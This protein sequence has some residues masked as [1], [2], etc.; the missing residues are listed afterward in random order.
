MITALLPA[1]NEADVLPATIASL[2]AQ[3][4][5]PDRIIVVSDN[6][7]DA[8]VR[9]AEQLNVDVIETVGN[10]HRKAGALNQALA[11]LD[12]DGLVL[13]MDSD[14]ELVPTWIETALTELDDPTVGA[15]GAVFRGDTPK[16]YLQLCQYL[17]WSRYAEQ[18]ERTGKTFVLSGTAALI[19]WEALEDVRARFGHWYDTDTI[20]EDSRLT[21]DLKMTGW[22]LRSRVEL[23]ATT[24]TMPS[25][26]MLWLQRRRWNLGAMQNVADLGFN[27]VTA[28]YWGQQVML[29]LCVLLL[30]G[31]IS[32]T[33]LALI[34]VG[35]TAPQLFWLSIGVVFIIERVLTVWDEPVRYRLFAALVVPELIY[36][37]ILQTAYVAAVVQKITGS[38]GSWHHV[39]PNDATTTRELE[40][41]R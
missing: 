27:R 36:A 28:P 25:V 1:H 30:W 12:R 5:S 19:R 22:K 37:L 38:A 34:I 10:T 21:L 23:Q 4:I 3:T 35:P 8:T 6:S 15:V 24:E 9:V 32:L 33:V 17:E 14:T 7:T 20:T 26:R 16:S 18:I 40:D 31:L 11:T 13:V 29:G 39:P 2:R 41:V